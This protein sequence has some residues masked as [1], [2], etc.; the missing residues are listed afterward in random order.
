MRDRAGAI[1]TLGAY[2]RVA[3]LFSP[4]PDFGGLSVGMTVGAI[5]Y[6]IR[7]DLFQARDEGEIRLFSDNQQQ[8]HLDAGIGLMA[9][10]Q[11]EQ[12][13]FEDDRV[14]AGLS[15][16]QIMIFDVEITEED[17][18]FGVQRVLHPHLM[19]GWYHMINDETW[20]EASSWFRYVQNA[21]LQADFNL[22][23]Q[24]NNRFWIGTGVATTQIVH[25]EIGVLLSENF[26]WIRHDLRI[27]LSADFPFNNLGPAFGPSFALGA[28]Y[29]YDNSSWY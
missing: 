25:T 6:R 14:Y 12:G 20:I 24:W 13:F 1:R 29:L 2:A 19:T 18:G 27:G 15:V 3:V 7:T 22:R 28:V 5:Q 17:G 8:M 9:Y 26:Q 16:P 21:P 23:L 11:L 10:R 4:E